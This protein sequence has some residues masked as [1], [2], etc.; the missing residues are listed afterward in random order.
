VDQL[1]LVVNSFLTQ[2]SDA[3]R[4]EII[5]GAAQGMQQ[6]YDDL[7]DFGN[8]QILLSLQRGAE[9]NDLESVKALFGP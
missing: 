3:R 1:L 2:M 7:R 9:E 6:N 5:D 8:Q 4:M